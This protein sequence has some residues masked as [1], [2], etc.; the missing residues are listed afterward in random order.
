[1]TGR[2]S[3]S[4]DV[5]V[6]YDPNKELI[7]HCDASPYGIGAVLSHIMD[8]NSEKPVAYMSHTLTPSQRNYSQIEREALAIIEAIKKFHQYLYGREFH[9]VT[10]HKPLLGLLAEYLF[11]YLFTNNCTTATI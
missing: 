3:C 4:A 8:D 2:S 10:D 6:H 5:L 1:M 11:I 7:L 9:L